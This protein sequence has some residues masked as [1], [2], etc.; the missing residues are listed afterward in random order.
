MSDE[1]WV[2]P[3]EWFTLGNGRERVVMVPGRV[4]AWL[5]SRCNL[6]D[7][8]I[9]SRGLDPEV[10]NVLTALYLAGLEWR[11]A[12]TGTREPPSAEPPAA[13]SAWVSSTTAAGLLGITDRAVRKAIADGR[14]DATRVANSWRITRESVEHYRARRSVA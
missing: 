13:S 3:A 1:Q 6:H 11:S 10:T 14:L 2:R 5:E 7:V 4:A 9:M 12:A 8:R